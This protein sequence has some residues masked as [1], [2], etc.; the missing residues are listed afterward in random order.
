MF[1]IHFQTSASDIF[2]L[3]S[4]AHDSALVRQRQSLRSSCGFFYVLLFDLRYVLNVEIILRY[5]RGDHFPDNISLI[6]LDRDNFCLHMCVVDTK[7]EAPKLGS[8]LARENIV[9]AL[10]VH[11]V[12]HVGCVSLPATAGFGFPFASSIDKCTFVAGWRW[13]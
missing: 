7:M 3:N 1:S 8:R 10:G 13:R 2:V 5:V 9:H 6:A 12:L 11:W 4:D